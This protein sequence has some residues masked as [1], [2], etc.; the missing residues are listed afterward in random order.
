MGSPECEERDQ[1]VTPQEKWRGSLQRADKSVPKLSS[2]SKGR[3]FYSAFFFF[4]MTDTDLNVK[5]G[6]VLFL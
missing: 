1:T 4:Q 3:A 5:S 2:E 6:N